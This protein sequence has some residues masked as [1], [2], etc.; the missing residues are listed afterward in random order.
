MTPA[1]ERHVL[2]MSLIRLWND[3]CIAIGPCADERAEG[4]Q[5][6]LR[7]I[8]NLDNPSEILRVAEDLGTE[9]VRDEL[10][11]YFAREKR[12]TEPCRDSGFIRSANYPPEEELG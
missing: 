1:F 10:K 5:F 7:K 9:R 6:L 4:L 3:D 8:L 12:D 2:T 11:L